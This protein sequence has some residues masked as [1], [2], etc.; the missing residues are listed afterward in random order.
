LGLYSSEKQQDS[1][2]SFDVDVDRYRG[3]P[4][5]KTHARD[6]TCQ[7][8]VHKS[9]KQISLKGRG[10]ET[11]DFDEPFPQ[12]A[13]PDTLQKQAKDTLDRIWGEDGSKLTGYQKDEAGP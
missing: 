4:C 2:F 7:K 12:T 9:A 10:R 1:K 3:L 5:S 6:K 13:S 11:L 8:I